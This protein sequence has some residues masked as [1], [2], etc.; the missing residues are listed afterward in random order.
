MDAQRERIFVTKMH[1]EKKLNELACVKKVYPSAT[2]FLLVHFEDSQHTF[3]YLAEH[4]IILRDQN[5]APGLENHL[6]ITIGDDADMEQL[7][8][9]LA[10]MR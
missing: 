8:D 5:H 7:L 1:V 2:N 6:R 10:L 9:C 4:G 3:D